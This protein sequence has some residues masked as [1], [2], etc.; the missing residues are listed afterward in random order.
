MI[1]ASLINGLSA[2]RR[3]TQRTRRQ[4]HQKVIDSHFVIP[5][6]NLH[7]EVRLTPAEPRRHEETL[8]VSGCEKDVLVKPPPIP[9]PLPPP[10]C[11]EIPVTC[12][13]GAPGVVEGQYVDVVVWLQPWTP[14]VIKRTVMRGVSRIA[15]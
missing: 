10:G 11:P 9:V 12:E 3:L 1:S 6:L 13:A 8:R 15:S 7:I 5:H 14:I 2:S 4:I